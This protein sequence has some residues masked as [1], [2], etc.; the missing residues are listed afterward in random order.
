MTSAAFT[1]L[2]REPI[3]EQLHAAMRSTADGSGCFVLLS[4]EA[5][6]GK[7]AVIERFVNALS[8]RERVLIGSCDYFTTPRPLGPL[9]DVAGGLGPAVERALDRTLA[10]SAV[11]ELFGSVLTDLRNRP[12]VLVVEDAHWADEA[13]L[14]LLRFLASRI[15]HTP[16]LVVVTYRAD[17]IGRTHPLVAMLGDVA[18]SPVIRRIAVDRLSRNAVAELAAERDIDVDELFR[19]T[20]GNPFF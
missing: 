13:T 14:D 20:S 18:T 3:L 11:H 17:E 9:L 12:T 7:T 5:G 15:D 8:N 1:L 4:G 2:E 19:I 16:V 10:G 6:A